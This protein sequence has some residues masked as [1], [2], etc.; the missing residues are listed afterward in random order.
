[1]PEYLYVS[2]SFAYNYSLKDA[3]IVFLG[4]PFSSTSISSSSIYGPLMVRESLKLIEG[5]DEES[6]QNIFKKFK[7]CDIGDLEVVPGSYKLTAK[8]IR[9]TL[10]EIREINKRAFLIFIGG[11]HLITLPIIETLKPRTIIQLDAHRDLR[12]E[13]LGKKFSHT[14]WAY[15]ATKEC[16][17]VQIGTRSCSEDEE[18]V[19]RELG[20]KNSLEDVK[21]PIY[22]TVDVDVFDP[23]YV[24]TGLPAYGGLLLKD[25]FEIIKKLNGKKIIGM[26]ITEIAENTL[27]SKT[28]FLASEIIKKVLSSLNIR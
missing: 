26:D 17:I 21:E 6:K 19:A 15:Y 1:M 18:M 20:I 27:P 3:D 16:N 13:Y 22:L 28:G 10:K 24:N 7:F 5:Y 9:N 25:V 8:R 23:C 11:E 2:N 14:T 4:I 12:K